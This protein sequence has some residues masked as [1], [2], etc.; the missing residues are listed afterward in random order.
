MTTLPRRTQPIRIALEPRLMFDG[1]AV[2]TAA[3]TLPSHD[4]AAQPAGADAS[5]AAPAAEHAPASVEH[6][7]PAHAALAQALAG[8]D[9]AGAVHADDAQTGAPQA[10]AHEPNTAALADTHHD[11]GL[12]ADDIAH[13]VSLTATAPATAEAAR[14]EI[15]FVDATLA[16]RDVLIAAL[17]THAEVVLLQADQDGV[18]QIAAALQGRSG[19]DAIH[20]LTHANQGVVEIGN[21][22]LD[23]ASIEGKYSVELAEIGAHLAANADVLI[24]GCDFA[25]GSNGAQAVM[26]LAHALNADIAASTDTTGIDGNWTLESHTGSIETSAVH[27]EAWQHDLLASIAVNDNVVVNQGSSIVIAPLSNDTL[28]LTSPS[29]VV[30]TAPLHGTLTAS[31]SNL[32][33]YTPTAGYY[34]SDSFTYAIRDVSALGAVTISTPATVAI[35]VNAAPVLSVPT[36]TGLVEDNAVTFSSAS[37]TRIAVSDPDSPNETVVLSVP[38]GTLA[39]NPNV[40]N[41]LLGGLLSGFTV[42][43]NA[44][45]TVTLSGPIANI[46]DALN[47][48]VYT[49][50]ADANGLVN[51]SISATDSSGIAATSTVAMNFAAVADIVPDTATAL[52]N[53]ASSFNLLAN[54]SFE[55]AGRVV[56]GFTAPAHGTLTVNAQGDAVYTPASGWTGSDTFNYTVTSGGT[57]ETATVTVTTVLPN[58]APTISVPAAQSFLE[59][60][61]RV[62]SSSLGNAI[63]VNDLNGGN[64]T[65]SLG[66]SN[67]SLTLAQ[68]S[69]LTLLSGSNGSAALV[70][71]GSIGAI[72]SALNGLTF[73]PLA[74]YN[75]PAS[76]SVLASDGIA[77]TQSASIALS[78]GAV[79]DGVADSIATGPVR[80]ISFSP[81]AN[82]N[83]ENPNASI[84]A[85]GQPAHGVAV[86]GLGNTVTYTPALGYTGSDSFTYTVTSGGVTEQIAVTVSVGNSAPTATGMGTLSTVDKGLVLLT[87]G[88]AFNDVD[89]PLDLLRYTASGLPAGLAIDSLTGLITGVVDGHASVNGVAGGGIYNV[90]VTATDLAG[91]QASS[92]L[93]INVSNPAPIPILGLSI[94]G[95]E[96]SLL[97]IGLDALLIVDPDGDAL[98]I[99]QASALHGTVVIDP[100]DSSLKYTPNANYFGLDTI[101]Y[102]VRDVDGGQ[103]TGSVLVVLANLPDLPVLNLPALPL[104]NEDTPLIFANLLGQRLS[105][106]DV[107]GGLL[108]LDLNVPVGSLSLAETGGVTLTRSTDANGDTVHLTGTVADLNLAL[109]SLIY[110]PGADYNGAVAL[111]LNLGQLTGGLLNVQASLPIG[112]AA[113]ADIVDDRVGLT[114]DTPVDFNVL[115]NDSFE[116]PGRVVSSFTLPAHGQLTL[117]AQG[118]AHYTPNAGYLG[119]DSFTYTVTSNGT[120]ETATVTLTTALPNYAPTLSVPTAQTLLEDASLRFGGA[121]A[122][123][124]ADRNNDVLSVT[125]TADHGALALAQTTG[126]TLIDGNGSDGTLAFSGSAAAINAAIDGLR[127]TPVADY[128]GPAS[129]NL[130]ASDGIAAVQSASVALTVS[131]VADG[132]ADSVQT[133]PLL[134][135]TFYPLAN[136]TFEGT[137]SIVGVS[138]AAHGTLLQIGNAVTYT[139]NAGYRGADSFT[140]TVS[141]GGATETI[142]INVAVGSNH[143]PVAGS[144]PP[145]A[146]VDAGL[147]AV[148]TAQA[149]VDLDLFDKL[150]Y[151]ASNLPA[152]LSIDANTGVISGVVDGHA[153]TVNGGVYA[154]LITATDLGGAQASS[155]LQLTVGNPAPLG[156]V[157]LAVTG[158]EDSVLTIPRASLLVVDPDGD[159]VSVT[160][161]SAQHGS[162]VVL[163]DGS[164]RYTPNANYFGLDTIT[165]ALRDADGGVGAGVVAVTVLPVLDLPTIQLP[166]LP[167]FAEDT[168][169]VFASVLGQR[170][171]VADVDGKLLDLTLSAPNGSFGFSVPTSLGVVANA[172]GS[173]HLQGSSADI[174]AALAALVYTPG[175]DYNGAL[176]ISLQLGQ[177]TGLLDLASLVTLA[178][179]LSIA[180]V[181]DIVADEVLVSLDT[182]TAFNVLANDNFENSGRVVSSL[183]GLNNVLTGHGGSVSFD[184]QG[185]LLYTPASGFVGDD[186]F[187]YTVSSNGTLETATVTLH[188]AM[189]NYAPSISAPASQSLAE[190]TALV[191][192]G[193]T[194]ISVADRNGDVLSITL[195]AEHGSLT[196]AGLAGLSGVSG[197]GSDSVSFSG[198]AAAINA[199]L[200]GL[201]FTPNADYNGPARITIGASDGLA[202]LQTGSVALSI[203]AVAD[204]VTDSLQTGPLSTVTFYP[205][206]NDTFSA[207]PQISGF[208]QGAHGVV[209]LGANGQM[210]YTPGTGYSGPDSF[211]YTVLSGGVS[212]TVAVNVTVGNQAPTVTGSLPTL[213]TLDGAIVLSIG[214][215]TAFRDG[216]SLDVL[217]Y[218]ASNLPS[219]LSIDPSSGVISGVVN[220]HASVNGP[221]ATG[222][223]SVTVTATDLAG[224]A[225][226]TLLQVN[227]GNPAPLGGVNLAV[228][229]NE[230]SVLTIPRAS[231]LVVDPDGDSVSVTGASAQHGSVVVLA[232]GSLRYTPNANYF[233]LDTITY[234]LRDADG[235]V[236]AG[237]VAVTVLPVLDL[238]TLQLPVLPVFAEDTPLV[239]ASVLGQ[240]LAV[241]DVD[242]KLLDLTLTAPNGSFGFSVPTSLGVVA[243]AGG[244][245]H[246]QGS[247]ADINAALA[248]L[249]YTPGADYNGALNI[250]LQLGQLTGLLG[251]SLDFA[252]LV[253]VALPVSIAAVADVVDDQVG[254]TQNLPVSFN[255]LANDSFENAG[256][257][258]TGHS[259]PAHGSLSID[260]QGNAIYTPAAGYLGSDSFTYTVTSNGTT[261]TATVTITTVLPNFAPTLSV[262]AA[263]TVNEDAPLVFAGANAISLADRNG[264]ILT[265]TLQTDHGSL[266]LAQTNGLSF[267]SGD[268]T[269]DPVMIV[270]GSVADLNAALNG[271]RFTPT[272]DY[273][274]S[275]SI[276]VQAFD[277]IAAPQSASIAV[278]IN[279][280]ADGVADTLQTEPQQPLTIYPLANDSFANPDATITSLGAA[281]HGVAV[282]GSGGAVTYT[283]AVGY[284]GLDSFTYTVTS[285]GVSETVTVSVIVGSNHAPVGV[286]LSAQ[287]TSDGAVVAIA[288]ATG[289]S[290]SDLFDRLTYSASGLPAGL[291]IDTSSGL[292]SGTVNGHASVL[293]P[294]GDYTVII[295]ATDLAGASAVS[296][297]ALHVGNP[298]PVAGVNVAVTASEDMTLT[299]P[300]AT[301]GIVDSDGDPVTVTGASALHGTVVVGADGS[302]SYTANANYNGADTITYTLRDSDGGLASGGV[303]VNVLPV[304]DLPSVQV[305]SVPVFNEDTALVFANLAGQSLA[306]GDVDGKLLDLTLSGPAGS[307]SF[308]QTAAV[309]VVGNVDGVLHLQ[310]SAAQI[311]AALSLLVFTPGADFNGAT[312]IGLQLGQLV[313]ALGSQVDA[314]SLVTSSLPLTIAPVADANNDRVSLTQDSLARFNVLANDTFENAGRL[315]ITFT[316]PSHGSVS[317]DPQGNAL[318]TP[319]AG[320]LGNDAFTYTVTSN[321][322]SETA[323]VSLAIAQPNYAPSVQAPATAS[324]SEDSVL[325]FSGANAIVVADRNGDSLTL[326][327]QVNHGSLS[328]GQSSGLTFLAGDGSADS[329][330]TVRGSA[331]DL[332]AALVT[333]GFTPVADYNGAAV[334]SVQA[335]DGLLSQAS[336]IALTITPVADGVADT[337][338]TGPLTPISFN[339]LAN[340][341]FSNPDALIGA[342]SA[343]GHGSVLLGM[344]GLVTYTPNPGYSGSDSFTYTVIAGGVSE[345][346]QVSVSIGNSAPTT[347][348]N[349]GSLS[350]DDRD[351]VVAVPTAQAFDD[352]DLRDVLRYSASG[353]PLGLTIDASSGLISGVVDGHASVLGLN[354]SGQYT[355]TVTATD[356]AGASVSSSLLVSVGNPPP[357]VA[358]GLVVSGNEDSAIAIGASALALT[359]RDGD[360]VA[361]AS[362]TALHGVVTINNDGS[363][364]YRPNANYNGADTITFTAVDADGGS[365]TGHIAVTLLPVLDLPTLRLPSVPAFAEDTPLVFAS[366]SGQALA[367]A[368]V[369]G[370]LLDLTLTA[371]NGSFGFSLPTSLGVVSNLNGSLH[372]QGSGAEINA[373]LSALVYT[374]GADYNGALNITLQLGQLSGVLGSPLNVASLVSSSLPLSIAAVADIV[375]DQVRVFQGSPQ[376]FNVLANDSFENPAAAVSSIDTSGTVGSVS[377]NAR[378]DM[379]YTAAAGFT[380]SDS[381]RYTVTSNGTTETATV[382][383]LVGPANVAPTLQVPAAQS[384]SEDTA[385]VLTGAN[386]IVVADGNG[387]DTLTVTLAASHG[388]LSLAQSNGLSFLAGTGSGD[389][390][391][392]FSGS[393]TAIN[394][395]LNGLRFSPLADYNG[396]AAIDVQVSD[397]IAPAQ[398]ARVD[399]NLAAVADGVADTVFTEPQVPVSF[400]PLGN[401]SFSNPDATISALGTPAHGSVSLGA[402]NLLTYTPA[403]GY[404]GADSFT[405]TVTAG[406]VSETVTVSVSVGSNAAPVAGSLQASLGNDASAVVIP[407]ASAFT[408]SDLFDRL[409]FSASNLPSGLS[410]DAS[411]GVINGTL[412]G[413]ASTLAPGGNYNV[414]ITATDLAGA[415]ASVVLAL[416]VD[417]PAPTTGANVAVTTNEDTPL[418]IPR[419]SLAIAD[420]DGD[421]VSVTAATALHGSVGIGADGAL[422]YTP[423]ANYNGADVIS[424]S[425]RDADGGIASGSVAVSVTPVYDAPTLQAPTLPALAEDTPLVFA[426][427]AG[428]RL[429]VG[430]VDGQVLDMRLSVPLGSFSLASVAGLSFSENSPG[431][432]H[433]SGSAAAINLAL[434][435]LVYT[436]PA[437]YNGSLNISVQLGQLAGGVLNVS[438]S[439]PLTITP[440]ADIVADH[441]ST[442]SDT[443]VSLN[444]LANDSFENA[445]RAVS[446]VSGLVNGFTANGGAVAWSSDGSLSYTPASG[447]S[448]NDTFSYT[449]TSGGVSETASITVS[450]SAVAN[451]DP[452]ISNTPLGDRPGVDGQPLRIDVSNAFSDPDGDALRF[453]ASGLPLGL[454][455]DPATGVIS[456]TLDSHAS[457]AR[458]GG[459][460]SVLVTAS[461][462]RGGEVSQGFTLTVSN[463]APVAGDDSFSVGRNTLL[464]GGQVL[465]GNVLGNDSDPD[466][467]ALRVQTTPLQAPSHGTLVLRADG[468][469]EYTPALNFSGSDSFS[470][471]L[472]DSDGGS[473][474]AVVSILVNALNEA[475]VAQGSIAA[476]TGTDGA[477]FVL[478]LAG[479]FSD[480]DNDSLRY[481][482]SGLPPGLS[483]DPASGLISGTLDGHASTGGAGGLYAVVISANDNHGGNATQSFTLSVA[484][485]IPVTTST[486]LVT[487]EDTAASG[488]LLASDADGDALSFAI[489]QGPA[490]GNLVLN[491]DN[492][493]SYLPNADYHGTDSFTYRVSD[494]DGGSAVATVNIV[495]SAVNDPPTAV[496]SIATQAALDSGSFNLP[497]AGNFADRDGT[498][499]SYSASGLP[500]GLSIDAAS[501][502]ISGTLGSSA[503]AAGPYTITVRASDGQLSAQQSFTLNVGNPLPIASGASVTVD[504]DG[505]LSGNLLAR[506]PDADSLVFA[507][508]TPPSHGR[509][510]IDAAG[511]YTYVPDPDYNGADAFTYRVTDADGGTVVARVDIQVNPV[512]DAPFAVG[513]V[514]AQRAT[515]GQPFSLDLAA[516]FAD[517]DSPALSYSATGLPAGLSLDASTG[518]ITGTLDRH[519]SSL[520]LGGLYNI[521]VSASDGGGATAIQNFTLTVANPIP[522]ASTGNFTSLE[523]TV[524]RGQ[525]VASDP[526]G[527]TLAFS[528]NVAPQHG[529][530][531]INRDGSFTYT[532]AANY[533]GPDSFTYLVRD[534]DGGWASAVVTLSI[535]AVNDAPLGNGS[536]G[537]QT[538]VDGQP[539]NLAVAAAFSDADGDPLSY[540]ASGLPPGLSISAD[541]V[542]S[543]TVGNHASTAAAGGVWNVVIRATDSGG[544]A[545]TQSFVLT[546]ANPPPQASG[547]ALVVLEDTRF[548]G[549]LIATDVDGDSLL[550]SAA[551]APQHGSLVVYP[552]GRFNYTPNANYSGSDSFTY[553]VTDADGGVA[554]ATLT[555]T[556]TPS[557]DVPTVT[558][559]IGA[560]AAVDGAPFSLNVASYFGDVDG[561]RLSYSVSGLPA[562]LVFDAVSGSI[563][564]TVNGHASVLATNGAYT[565]TVNAD[566]GQG[567]VASQSFVLSVTNTLPS[568]PGGL[569]STAA[570]SVLQGVLVASD[571]DGDSLAFSAVGQ[572]AHGSLVLNADGSFSYTP[573]S[574]YVGADS[575]SYRVTD[576]DGGF[577]DATVGLSVS[578]AGG[579][580][581]APLA[582]GAIATQTGSDGAPFSLDLR[583]QFSDADGDRLTYV[584]SNLPQGL[585]L[586]ADGVIRG[587]LDGHASSGAP[588]GVY[589]VSVSATDPSGA[590]AI[591]TFVLV[592]ANPA[593]TS[594]GGSFSTAEG[595]VLVGSLGASDVDGDL[596]SFQLAVAPSHGSLVLNPDGS[597]TYTPM[598]NYSGP[599]SFTYQVRDNDG[600][601]ANAS[602]SLSVTPINHAPTV[603]APLASQSVSDG[604][605]VSLNIAA[606]FGD[607]DGQALT[608][609]A[610]G[611]PP[612]LLLNAQTGVI[613]GTVAANASTQGS[614]GSGNYNVTLLASDGQSS[615]GQVV[616]FTAVNPLPVSAGGTLGALENTPLAGQ[617]NA[618]DPDGDAIAFAVAQPPAHGSVAINPDGSFFY[619]PAAN[620]SGPDSFTYRVTDADGGSVIATLSINV[621]AV[622]SPPVIIP[623]GTPTP[624]GGPVSIDLSSRATDADRDPLTVTNASAGHGS[625]RLDG[626][627]GVTYTPAPGYSGA[628]TIVYTLSDGRGGLAS[629]AANLLVTQPTAVVAVGTGVVIDPVT[630][631]VPG[632]ALAGITPDSSARDYGVY[633]R[634]A[635]YGMVIL[636]AVNGVKRLD[637]LTT[638]SGERPISASVNGLSS[639]GDDQEIIENRSS[640]D[641]AVDINNGP[642]AQSLGDIESQSRQQVDIDQMSEAYRQLGSEEA[643]E[644]QEA[645]GSVDVPEDPVPVAARGPLTFGEQL[646]VQNAR[647]AREVETLARWLAG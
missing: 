288:A 590:S 241:A 645:A 405:Y 628:D 427:L 492:S 434:N 356:L 360:S 35:V 77:A 390:S 183:G 121:N 396:G 103:A 516:G 485:T 519:A 438:S 475:P 47:G 647:Q 453:S 351:L 379:I 347:T 372:L 341:S 15:Y 178:L 26:A 276:Q 277:G 596:L 397:G 68:L 622:N 73:T 91:A 131:P 128:H 173:L 110:T 394:A 439:L 228:T 588:G 301:L 518:V 141:S 129:L 86:L 319:A 30:Q 352:A 641:G 230:D 551:S 509:V 89:A 385:L 19:I 205:L 4:A 33:T 145:L 292:I 174:N 148:P 377:F 179:P 263:Q 603:I 631:F 108:T 413:H 495:V 287:S 11:A 233:G 416:H 305:P 539:F 111:T 371:P 346:V 370:K 421:L 62:F 625:V 176:N 373:A 130:T 502:V 465:S 643:I 353:L 511:A 472:L 193:A 538:G 191:L 95:S 98:R 406:G 324:L 172:G 284:R 253:T 381:F 646:Q 452:L 401:D 7:A 295:T 65:V 375:D 192:A 537:A 450:V 306:V 259:D 467:D 599:D 609:S 199:A 264:D 403:L 606:S 85:L 617:L 286:D 216:D 266:S 536:L 633:V 227:V 209:S 70:V 332:N 20:I 297:L 135:V 329:S 293:A 289:F 616:A 40:L 548:D 336:A 125:L 487:A 348:A 564:G 195:A 115:A 615:V 28:L 122:I 2:A 113:V 541:G 598:A 239:F 299:I 454:S 231:L 280:V 235:G 512:N 569:F 84:T 411:T 420:P 575:F 629:G 255:V 444:L 90:V 48:L 66:A 621:A 190:D 291:S 627:G 594:V 374:P 139:P 526:D 443:P 545:A 87:A 42:N 604:A 584:A 423:N 311:N 380:G 12:S 93:T 576:S 8:A 540:S 273:N 426:N 383:L 152:G 510:T 17:P 97:G 52:L 270:R 275:A 123:S 530:L 462:G 339:P 142:A 234:N 595:S 96:D 580:N 470:Y 63:S 104:L 80:P 146:T 579:S 533:H 327:L 499:L 496:G 387:A 49:P 407:T 550:F 167:V 624:V 446:V 303:A 188:V 37:G 361:V 469:F 298:P 72:N 490:H 119:S 458:L 543:G 272:A 56:S 424:Y 445:N 414:L 308:S 132:V 349:L 525:L 302:L 468:S 520:A 309:S 200:N 203:G 201:V 186:S 261:E 618:F 528:T 636:D 593:P 27:A 268:G 61:P 254:A 460:Y 345:T 50:V 22:T 466:G 229:G 431:T 626:G 169:L 448:G 571:A 202:A 310:G 607:R 326:T 248:A 410:I 212:E 249:V 614:N 106:G 632:P 247:S 386:A 101:T 565:V 398:S 482:A 155:N 46:N 489:V 182:P 325:G 574:G 198:S 558:S 589:T 399:L 44:T 143:P 568:T 523:D 355:V 3:I 160:G 630:P 215:A 337:L 217:R 31:G 417:N 43:G 572:P 567:G 25:A 501:G 338:Q 250:S 36:L 557:N 481:S 316:Q 582:N 330:F 363:L 105:L 457:S 53:T 441:L 69:G 180:P 389:S 1:A 189:P 279:P 208:S 553:R 602:V 147:V 529:D 378:G 488:Q 474:T 269:A 300:R 213:N 41:A 237:V 517:I 642:M 635:D 304:L 586:G 171:A 38:K 187:T 384:G 506:D 14:H 425:V 242:G 92:N 307:F 449:V 402:N 83:F 109:N 265:V 283:P 358:T 587:T 343:A 153:S 16:E 581:Q 484:N 513:A 461:D 508:D 473:S 429:T 267:I 21:S 605:A 282:L 240:R 524:L 578:A 456:G 583:G 432:L 211:S 312:S 515:D 117:D 9:A 350:L 140:Y 317:I 296:Q 344:N 544:L 32:V 408:D 552:D 246:L 256:R 591:Q 561:D 400:S 500:A 619:R 71:S 67:G 382:T 278:A 94:G 422:T 600:G 214:T 206:A 79:A 334:L 404:R 285:G 82:D 559:S 613:S 76:I 294:G 196:L 507:S 483:I 161:A 59:D 436:P 638:L 243:N 435:G 221:G 455:L 608:Y 107:D 562:G 494:A 245:L 244:S 222:S 149:F 527:D 366:L 535:A 585:S 137:P 60:T 639:L 258:V 392:T 419:G 210:S 442:T 480:I 531:L 154:I 367:V 321:G 164:L 114:L 522:L 437:D 290:D 479:R 451:A 163:A 342:V 220:G 640:S 55:N 313:G 157:N 459:A 225:V 39:L 226:S 159:S 58:Y 223:Y 409:S 151:S 357:S 224:A 29:L 478:S 64:L 505:M 546:I 260:A 610:I 75:G 320:Y 158:N 504:E 156:G 556:V 5:H 99:T 116:N 238:P 57:T 102:I 6:L 126:L 318:Y 251:S 577:S 555:L 463:P 24:Y 134:P 252:S 393:A 184:A 34:G 623:G 328:L 620:Y 476:Q 333:L 335:S 144:L 232:D 354:G 364:T 10:P 74:D 81:L 376:G 175:A 136:D 51:L 611:L 365:A 412:D 207:S 168:P 150:T 497:V 314:A 281:A 471:R 644:R 54:D 362:A 331:Q 204:G 340:D 534:S 138:A 112:I 547:S 592:V 181:V 118:Q 271:L 323:T 194:A 369:D 493:Y 262:P 162:V 563:S 521:Q 477:P 440:V 491:A 315:V 601:I 554:T 634:E 359:D 165:Y 388:T 447:F 503:S 23:S 13:A 391:V 219:G 498:A 133:E 127:F 257:T 124:V 45:G 549:T 415:S 368:D 486:P 428:Q 430:D 177:L 218:S 570:N 170:L 78:L 166:V 197:N 597:F 566:D 418:L 433:F 18:A 120:V 100:V 236:G 542:I 514:A 532:P 274:G 185:N 395:A 88:L 322:T 560:R 464:N 637:G 573:A 612:G